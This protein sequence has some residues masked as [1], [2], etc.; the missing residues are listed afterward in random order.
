MDHR[1]PVIDSVNFCSQCTAWTWS[2]FIVS[3]DPTSFTSPFIASSLFCSTKY[4]VQI[5]WLIKSNQEEIFFYY[6]YTKN[7]GVWPHWHSGPKIRYFSLN[8]VYIQFK[9]L[10]YSY[11]HWNWYHSTKLFHLH[12]GI[13]CRDRP[14]THT[15]IQ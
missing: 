2:R 1:S 3:F 15:Y 7:V 14:P 6:F 5:D 11:N 8:K 4:P 13:K 9:L 10:V 12:S